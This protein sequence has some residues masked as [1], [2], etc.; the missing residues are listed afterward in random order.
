MARDPIF[1]LIERLGRDKLDIAPLRDYVRRNPQSVHAVDEYG[2][3]PVNGPLWQT[4]E[5]TFL[6]LDYGA[7][8]NAKDREGRTLLSRASHIH[9]MLLKDVDNVLDYVR[10]LLERG[11]DPN[12]GDDYNATP[13]FKA[14]FTFFD[15]EEKSRLIALL[16]EHGAR[17]DAR[18]RRNNTPLHEACSVPAGKLLLDYGADINAM[19]D[20]GETP[21]ITAAK[22]GPSGL[23]RLLLRNGATLN[24]ADN[25]G[26]TPLHL[27][28]REAEADTGAIR[29]LLQFGANP[30]ARNIQGR[31]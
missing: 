31:T 10:R 2:Q 29:R 6:L 9:N 24:V 14:V 4:P 27:A 1:N 18:D 17:V 19:N 21:L 5:M 7:D 20:R 13:L 15:A 28:T 3:T 16:L 8:I 26:R 22:H 12:I 23:T 30:N 25:E 11:A